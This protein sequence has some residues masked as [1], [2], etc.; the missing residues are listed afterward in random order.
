[1]YIFPDRW[2]KKTPCSIHS[3]PYGERYKIKKRPWFPVKLCHDG[4]VFKSGSHMDVVYYFDRRRIEKYLDSK[5]ARPI[6]LLIIPS[7]WSREYGGERIEEYIM[8]HSKVTGKDIKLCR[9]KIN[10][11][12]KNVYAIRI[13]SSVV[14]SIKIRYPVIR[15]IS[16]LTV[17]YEIIDTLTDNLDENIDIHNFYIKHGITILVIPERGFKRII[18]YI[19]VK[20]N[21][22]MLRMNYLFWRFRGRKDSVNKAEKISWRFG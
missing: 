5:R 10:G 7:P 22:F 4:Y 11:H 17:S 18:D 20:W 9:V 21:M 8:K 1:M 16:P 15:C 2:A 19:C 13:D 3:F 12:Y 14:E 6:Y